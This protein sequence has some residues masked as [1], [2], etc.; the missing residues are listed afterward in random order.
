MKTVIIIGAGQMGTSVAGLLNPNRV[1]LLGFGDNNPDK[2]SGDSAENE[3]SVKN[4]EQLIKNGSLPIMSVES[5]IKLDPEMII[6]GVIG[7]ERSSQLINQI[8][9]LGYNNEIL[10]LTDVYEL[11]DIRSA[12]IHKIIEQLKEKSVLGAI[13]ELGVFKGDTAWQ[14]NA[15]MPDRK[16]YLFDTFEGFDSTDVDV[17]REKKYS[18]A[19]E[20]D[21]SD[22]SVEKILERFSYSEQIVVRKGYFPDTADGLE[23]EHYA[24]VSLDAD[25]YAPTLSGLEYFYPRLSSGGVIVL[26]DYGN[27]Q[28]TGVKAAVEEYEKEHGQLIIV[29]LVDL[30]RS[31]VIVHP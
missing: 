15:L 16:L 26:H 1:K 22:T 9:K 14:L 28:F 4:N 24:F 7:E 13:A 11:F 29:P 31:C 8:K 19:K 5:A 2:W 23:H 30:H 25:L 18:G 17:E 21:F 20:G 3:A 6:I 10:L 12:T 27:S